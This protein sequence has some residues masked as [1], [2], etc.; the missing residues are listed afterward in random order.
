ML[1]YFTIHPSQL[2]SAKQYCMRSRHN[3]I[4]TLGKQ[5]ILQ[6]IAVAF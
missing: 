3:F 5:R 2:L 1:I 4:N 6:Q